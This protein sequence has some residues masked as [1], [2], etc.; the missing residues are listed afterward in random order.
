M[1]RLISDM[2][3]EC[4]KMS[5]AFDTIMVPPPCENQEKKFILEANLEKAD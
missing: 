4:S 5:V 2:K 3:D 1:K